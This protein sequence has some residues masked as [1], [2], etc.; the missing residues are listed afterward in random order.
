MRR[1][2]FIALISGAAALPLTARAQKPEKLPTVGFLGAG[3]R[4]SWSPWVAAFLQGLRD[5]GWIEGRNIAIEYRWAEGHT[6]RLAEVAAEFVQLKVNVIVTQGTLPAL[7]AKQATSHIPIVF[8]SAGDPVGTGLVAS[9]AR[10]GGNVTG[11][12]SQMTD[13]ATKRL[14][15][16]REI[17][18]ALRKLGLITNDE[19]P[20]AVQE[21]REVRSVAGGLG[22]EVTTTQ[23]RRA[24]DIDPAFEALRGR[25]DAIYVVAD[26]QIAN[27][28]LRI[29]SLAIAA[30]IPTIYGARESVEAGGLISYG[31]SYPDQFRR[32]AAYVD[33]ILRGVRPEDIPIEQPTRFELILNLN[34][35][36]ALGLAVPSSVLGRADEVI[37]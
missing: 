30:R 14:E 15:L 10:P 7:A 33:R 23:V 27:N 35:A 20:T 26:P 16:L 32:S 8:A 9:L 4:A 18:P 24:E 12:S 19:N 6:E 3:T 11:L 5:L 13:T 21:T 28:R 34:S 36:K 2:E 17:L 29:N 22:L 37:E 31:T 1:R 25:A